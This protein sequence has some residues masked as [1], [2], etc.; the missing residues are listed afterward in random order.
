MSS[1]TIGSPVSSR[2]SRRISSASTPSPWKVYGEVRGL[3][4]PP[5]SIVAPAAA[6]ARAV[7]SVCSRYST[8]HGPGDEAE[9]RVADP[10]A[11]DLD[12]GR[13]GRELARDELVGLE[14]RQHLLDARI[15]LER[16]RR[17]QLALA[18]RA[19]HGRLAPARDARVDAG[20]LE[21]RDDVLGLLGRRAR[22][23]CTIR[24]SG[25]PFVGHRR[26]S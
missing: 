20:L 24:S 23:P 12:H 14:D 8:V 7:S 10:P 26:K 13:V 5:R 25:E 3:N 2:A 4:A 11:V 1:V 21:P 18:D 19:D 15:A 16:Q 17:E 22:R 6:T 9:G